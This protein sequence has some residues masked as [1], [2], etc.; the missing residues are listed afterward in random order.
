MRIAGRNPTS[1]FD[2][3]GINYVLFVQ[4]CDHRC[5]GCHNPSTWDFEGGYE[6]PVEAVQNHIQRYLRLI[7]GLTVSGGDPVYQLE[8]TVL[9][10]EWAK[11]KGLTVTLYTGF[12]LDAV[13]EK[14][15]RF[16]LESYPFDYIVDGCYK[17]ECRSTDCAFRGSSN[18]RVWRQTPEG[19]F[20]DVSKK[21]DCSARR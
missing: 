13:N 17:E 21:L 1:L 2:G 6:I 7:T 19:V 11:R 18:Q 14:L 10:A 20:E 3:V 4:G 15:K 9:L 5:E 8:E 12:E 16:E